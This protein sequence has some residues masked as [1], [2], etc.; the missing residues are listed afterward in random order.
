VDVLGL[1][2]VLVLGETLA[3]G[4][5]LVL[6]DTL[7]WGDA[8]E[9]GVQPD[10]SAAATPPNGPV[11]ATNATEASRVAA[12]VARPTSPALCSFSQLICRDRR[13]IVT[14]PWVV[15][16]VHPGSQVPSHYINA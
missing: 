7:V 12:P 11:N 1:G 10:V 15:R 8:L 2:D 16:L 9:V 13:K 4:D 3:L 5:V 6:G 14:I